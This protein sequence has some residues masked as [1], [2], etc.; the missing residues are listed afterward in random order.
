ML[1]KIE[2]ESEN[3]TKIIKKIEAKKF[4][5]L[6]QIKYELKGINKKLK[7]FKKKEKEI[8]EKVFKQQKKTYQIRVESEKKEAEILTKSQSAG[9]FILA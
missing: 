5:S 9:K 8:N 2:K 4:D 1:E 7:F 3:I 6:E